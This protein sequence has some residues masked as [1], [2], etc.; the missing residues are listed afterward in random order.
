MGARFHFELPDSVQG[1]DSE[2]T[3]ECRGTSTISNIIG[4]SLKGTRCLSISVYLF[5]KWKNQ[6]VVETPTFSTPAEIF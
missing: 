5:S 6:L 3:I 2:D 1:V 4:Y